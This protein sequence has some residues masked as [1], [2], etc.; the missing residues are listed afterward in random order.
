M[1]TKGSFVRITYTGRIKETGELFDTT[2][3]ALAKKEGAFSPKM[4]YGPV[5]II[6]GEGR[7]VKGLDEAL[8]QM[9]VGDERV[10]DVPA[11]RGFGDRSSELVKL[12]PLQ[13]FKRQ[14]F[15]PQQGMAITMNNLRGRVLSVN[16]GRVRVD[17][18]HPLAGKTLTYQLRV[19]EQVGSRDA[20]AK[21]IVEFYLSED[22]DVKF[23]KDDLRNRGSEALQ[24]TEGFEEIEVVHRGEIPQQAKQAVTEDLKKYLGAVAVR[25]T[26]LMETS[27]AAAN[28]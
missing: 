12:I 1:I 22:V 14:G 6:V 11:E 24:N 18:N 28:A 26:Q 13:E 5:T 25:F 19:E 21:G 9:K 7:V 10:I 4:R 17:F 3:E 27:K 2:D 15:V 20:Q 8:E 16:S 23:V